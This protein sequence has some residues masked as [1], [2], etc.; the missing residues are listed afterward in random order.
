LLEETLVPTG[1]YVRNYI[2]FAFSK[3]RQE[4]LFAGTS[5]GDFAC[6]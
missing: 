1:S 3:P 5:S 2:S 4:F 6:F